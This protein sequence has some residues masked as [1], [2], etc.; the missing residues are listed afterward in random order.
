MARSLLEVLAPCWIDIYKYPI[1]RNCS[2]ATTIEQAEAQV[3]QLQSEAC[4]K[5]NDNFALNG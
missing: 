3:K 5:S 1:S 2:N 4:G